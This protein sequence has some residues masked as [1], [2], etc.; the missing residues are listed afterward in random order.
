MLDLSVNLNSLVYRAADPA[1]IL[2]ST[3]PANLYPGVAS[4]R[5]AI[6]VNSAGLIPQRVRL[7]TSGYTAANEMYIRFG[8]VTV[9]ATLET[10]MLL[11]AGAITVMAIPPGVTHIASI[12]DTAGGQLQIWALDN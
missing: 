8:D 9:V 10:D 1:P 12:R 2:S 11:G 4:S 7:A 3:A 6:P 5:I